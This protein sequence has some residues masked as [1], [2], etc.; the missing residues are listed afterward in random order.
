[1]SDKVQGLKNSTD[2]GGGDNGRPKSNRSNQNQNEKVTLIPAGTPIEAIERISETAEANGGEYKPPAEYEGSFGRTL[3]DSSSSEDGLITVVMPPDQVENVTTQALVRIHSY[4]DGRVFVGAV[5]QGPFYDPDGLRADSPTMVVSAVS[6][7]VI[8]PSHHGR[9]AVS[10]IGLEHNGRIGPA[11]RRPRPNSPVFIVPDE[12]MSRILGLR[13]DFSLGVVVGHE[14]VIVPV[15]VRDKSVLYRHTGILGTTGGGKSTTVTNYISG[16]RDN[17]SAVVLLDTEGE[18]TTINEPTDNAVM[19][20]LLA[21]R[22][23]EHRGMSDTHVY[24]LIG[25]EPS[26]PSHPNNIP[27]TLSFEALSPYALIEILDMN[28][29]QQSRFLSA[30][31]L[32]KRFL[33]EYRIFPKNAQEEQ[34]ILEHDEQED[35]YPHLTLSFL[36]D[37][38][39]ACICALQGQPQP[40]NILNRNIFVQ[41]WDAIIRVVNGA[42]LEKSPASWKKVSSLLW[43]LHRLGIFDNPNAQRLNMPAMLQAGRVNIIDL[44]D[45]DSPILRNLA[46]AQILRQLQEAQD[47]NYVTATAQAQ[48]PT[49]VNVIIEEAH[50]FLSS[51]RIRQMPIL[52]QQLAKIAKRGRKRWLGLT[53]VTQLPQNLPDE[54]LA[55][56]NSWVLHKIQDE[57]VVN[58]LRKTIPSIDP[59]LWR[60]I[61]SLRAGQAVVQFAHMSRPMLTGINP[62]PF[63]LRLEN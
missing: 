27:F 58:R 49:P 36:I 3:F 46:I 45:L 28:D 5:S 26:N 35:G 48:V 9:A 40:Q 44:Y 54:V 60:M 43:R 8:M 57:S 19:I 61:A 18:Y 13:G 11:N 17:G 23:I 20:E 12:E 39:T 6:G 55:L 14:R 42:N 33:R 29:A 10:I 51:A 59:S 24:Y 25:R 15:P 50:E 56:I 21:E 62:S 52:Y 32:A 53:F 41:N 22:G 7:A 1:M 2:E 63:R 4:P 47:S 37:V 38:V 34:L 16:L 31:D 30:Y